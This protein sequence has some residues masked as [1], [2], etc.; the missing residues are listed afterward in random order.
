VQLATLISGFLSEAEAGD[1][2]SRDELRVMRGTLAHVLASDLSVRDAAAV[3]RGDV[4]ALVRDLLDAGVPAQRATEVVQALRPVY[5][6]GMES[7]LVAASPLVGFAAAPAGAPSPSPTTAVLA[8]SEQA[9]A[10][11]V[12]AIFIAF[13]L[14]AIG[15]VVTIL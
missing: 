11:T 8:L 10:W 12:R 2:Y 14:T 4:E 15:L 3:R 13:V 9:V 1:A 5:A 7:G 6:H